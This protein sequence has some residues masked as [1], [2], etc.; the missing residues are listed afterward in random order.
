[1][2]KGSVALKVN[3]T[4]KIYIRM[5]FQCENHAQINVILLNQSRIVYFMQL[6][7]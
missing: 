1:M 4:S 6:L 7:I 2:P 3:S 5:I